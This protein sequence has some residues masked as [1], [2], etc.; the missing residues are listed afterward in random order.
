MS[1]FS[2]M[3]KGDCSLDVIII[4]SPDFV[5]HM[6]LTYYLLLT[7][8]QEMFTQFDKECDALLPISDLGSLLRSMGPTYNPSQKEI[9]DLR[10]RF[11]PASNVHVQLINDPQCII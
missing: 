10:A 2:V 9:N 3:L 7:K 6:K 5:Y 8:C 11:L 1:P 4:F